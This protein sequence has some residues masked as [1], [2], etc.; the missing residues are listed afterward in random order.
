MEKYCKDSIKIAPYLGSLV[1][2][3]MDRTMRLVEIYSNGNCA[4]VPAVCNDYPKELEEF[5][6]SSIRP[7]EQE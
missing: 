2:V 1:I 6:S 3:P 4:C 5:H 7:I